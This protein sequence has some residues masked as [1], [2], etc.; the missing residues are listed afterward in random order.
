M[1]R[2]QF[3]DCHKFLEG[4]TGQGET[5]RCKFELELVDGVGNVKS[6]IVVVDPKNESEYRSKSQPVHWGTFQFHLPFRCQWQ[7]LKKPSHFFP[8]SSSK[9]GSKNS[10]KLRS[11]IKVSPTF[12]RFVLFTPVIL[13]WTSLGSKLSNLALANSVSTPSTSLNPTWTL[14]SACPSCSPIPMIKSEKLDIRKRM[15]AILKIY[16]EKA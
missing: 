1:L 12:S 3:L 16:K 13:L 7:K 9:A 6:A 8:I 5:S 10:V 15:Q 4:I 11:I 14:S 2:V